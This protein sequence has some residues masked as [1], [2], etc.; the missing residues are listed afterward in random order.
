MP[1]LTRHPVNII[2]SISEKANPEFSSL[3]KLLPAL[4]LRLSVDT[5]NVDRHCLNITK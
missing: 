1:G 5:V 2:R 3:D 4:D